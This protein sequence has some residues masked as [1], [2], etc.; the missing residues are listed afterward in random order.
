MAKYNQLTLLPFQGLKQVQY[1]AFIYGRA[2]LWLTTMEVLQLVALTNTSVLSLSL[3]LAADKNVGL[4]L[5]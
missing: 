2:I 1:N 5:H 4:S 3:N